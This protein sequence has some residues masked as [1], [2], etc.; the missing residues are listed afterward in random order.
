MSSGN[1]EPTVT[2]AA[3]FQQ[4]Q[5]VAMQAPLQLQTVDQMT[6][7]QLVPAEQR[8]VF[9]AGV[10]PM[11]TEQQLLMIFT[12][13]DAV[14]RLNLFKPFNNSRT[15]KVRIQIVF[16][17]RA[18]PTGT[19]FRNAGSSWFGSS[20]GP[21]CQLSLCMCIRPSRAVTARNV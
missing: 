4:R 19:V 18:W 1:I 8:T 16:K 3:L 13:F 11:I 21:V 9:F 6:A 20:S 5:A 17:Y 2:T 10:P 12:R 7:L 14:K 15:S